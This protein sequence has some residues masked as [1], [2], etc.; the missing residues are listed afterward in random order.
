MEV[1][2]STS[3]KAV[4]V[5]S[6][7]SYPGWEA[8]IDGQSVPVRRANYLFRA[9]EV[10]PGDHVVQFRFDPLSWKVGLGASAI[11]WLGLVV[12]A[13]SWILR[14]FRPLHTRRMPGLER[15]PVAKEGAS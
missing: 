5:V 8:S 7:I 13:V 1:T 3:E 10:P 14:P 12:L 11:T 6:E 4:L 15:Q 2:V 9:V